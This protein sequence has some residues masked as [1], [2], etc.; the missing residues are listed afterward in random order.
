MIN[1][2][3][4]DFYGKDSDNPDKRLVGGFCKHTGCACANAPCELLQ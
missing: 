2:L 4:L 3:K 1:K